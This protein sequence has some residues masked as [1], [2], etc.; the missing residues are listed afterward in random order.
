MTQEEIK[1]V[2]EDMEFNLSMSKEELI[3]AVD[4]IKLD[5]NVSPLIN[6]T[7]DV[8]EQLIS[9]MEECCNIYDWNKE[10]F[11]NNSTI[12]LNLK[13]RSDTAR[14]K[15]CERILGICNNNHLN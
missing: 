14:E 6:S 5:E 7:I 15:F 11:D 10:Q 8:V 9:T 3:K 13:E 12:L 1:K 2:V 4:G